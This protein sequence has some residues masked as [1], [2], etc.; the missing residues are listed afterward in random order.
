[1]NFLKLYL[2]KNKTT[3]ALWYK[4]YHHGNEAAGG[5]ANIRLL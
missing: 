1:M 2:E 4:V 5:H 3:E